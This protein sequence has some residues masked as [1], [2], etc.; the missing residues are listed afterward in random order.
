ML[1]GAGP[2]LRLRWL[3]LLALVAMMACKRNDAPADGQA[4]KKTPRT[5]TIWWAQ[6]APADGLQELGQDYESPEDISLEGGDLAASVELVE[7]M[8]PAKVAVVSWG[9][10][11]LHALLDKHATPKPKDEVFPRIDPERVMLWPSD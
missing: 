10:E 6:W 9:G 7:D 8:G 11:R 4:D 1:L 2:R 3:I 5:V